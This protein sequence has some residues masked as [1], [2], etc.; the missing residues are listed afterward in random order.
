MGLPRVCLLKLGHSVCLVDVEVYLHGLWVPLQPAGEHTHT[1]RG[2]EHCRVRVQQRKEGA[3]T[4]FSLGLVLTSLGPLEGFTPQR[5]DPATVSITF[6]SFP[7]VRLEQDPGSHL[8]HTL[9]R[10]STNKD[11]S[12]ALQELLTST[13]QTLRQ[14]QNPKSQ[15]QGSITAEAGMAA[16]S[17]DEAQVKSNQ[18]SSCGQKRKGR[19]KEEPCCFNWPGKPWLCCC[20]TCYFTEMSPPL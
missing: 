10:S 19:I 7:V 18:T 13:T 2:S 17:R 1:G 8:P 3:K 11:R 6:Q 16:R 12:K 20:R 15:N 9:T 5:T 14:E 4:P